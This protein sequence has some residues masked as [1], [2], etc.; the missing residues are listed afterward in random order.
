MKPLLYISILFVVIGQIGI[1]CECER[2]EKTYELIYQNGDVEV[3]NVSVDAHSKAYILKGDFFP[4]SGFHPLRSGVRN[5]YR[6][7][8]K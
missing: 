7:K 8:N 1:S 2:E 3:V 5:F 4:E 6:I